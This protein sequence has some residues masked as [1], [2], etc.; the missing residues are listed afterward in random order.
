MSADGKTNS[1]GMTPMISKVSLS[2]VI[3]R[4]MTSGAP[5]SRRS[6]NPWVT[7]AIGA[8]PAQVSSDGMTRPRIAGTPS[9]SK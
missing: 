4:P 1:R 9:V 5:P 7:T 2:R 3:V 6:Q 8:A